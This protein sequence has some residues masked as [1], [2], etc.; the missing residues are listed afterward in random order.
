MG[1]KETPSEKLECG[2]VCTVVCRV[3]QCEVSE[4]GKHNPAA[5]AEQAGALLVVKSCVWPCTQQDGCN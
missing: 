3:V 5:S 1:E 2:S 4:N